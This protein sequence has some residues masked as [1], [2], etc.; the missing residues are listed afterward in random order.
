MKTV[1][2]LV[3]V[4]LAAVAGVCVLRVAQ[5]PPPAA[6][7]QAIPA[8]ELDGDAAVQRL[9]AALRIR[10][11]SY[12]D[13]AQVDP[14]ALDDFAAHLQRSFPRVHA[15][16]QRETV[17]KS[18]LYTWPGADP[19]GKPILL[20]AH[21]DVVPVEPGTEAKWTQPP[22]GGVVADGYIWGRGARD[23]K[24]SVLALLEAAEFLLAAGF[25]PPRTVYLAFGHD[26]E[27]GGQQGAKQVAA[28]LRSRGVMAEFLLDEGGA[29]LDGLVAGVSRPVAAIMSA[30][31]GYFTVQLTTRAEGGHSSRPPPQTAVGQLARAVARVQDGLL[32]THLVRPV[33]D[34]LD[35]LA[36]EMAFTARLALANRWLFG[37]LIERTFAGDP[38][39][40]TLVRTTTAPT[41]FHAG[42]KDN[43]LPSE[44]SALVNF[45]LLPGDTR[46]GV[47]AHLRRVI[48]DEG[49]ELAPYGDFGNE[50][51][52][53]APVDNAAFALLARTAAELFPAAAISTGLVTGAT[54]AR[55]YAG[56]Y[57]SRY[58]FSPSAL[59]PE[60]LATVHGTNERLAV[61]NYLGMIRFYVQLLRNWGR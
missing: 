36:P 12:L 50:A 10:T 30:E 60:D 46:D 3:A 26:E 21:M 48:D 38:T 43:V 45:R 13:R 53:P 22:F 47:L 19:A 25:Q 28:L 11:I 6:P 32:P 39:T 5:L 34:M 40:N 44:A 18:L 55:N 17:G 14:Q 49:V 37:P 2:G 33:T 41:V 51:S 42:I 57:E 15:A 1:L 58:N 9:A 59:R 54:D 56:V 29:V 27:I 61:D 24:S 35:R 16:L 20:I 52:E 23:D 4:V 31:K 7:G 8:I